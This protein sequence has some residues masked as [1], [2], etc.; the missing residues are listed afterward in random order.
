[1]HNTNLTALVVG[2]KTAEMVAAAL[3]GR[4]VS[5]GSD[6]NRLPSHSPCTS[7]LRRATLRTATNWFRG[8]V[9]DQRLFESLSSIYEP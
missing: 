2:E 5:G 6:G 7:S 3:E 4:A 1:M 9:N 8:S